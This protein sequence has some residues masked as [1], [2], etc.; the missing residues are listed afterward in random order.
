MIKT[1]CA[2]G[3]RRATRALP[4]VQADMMVITTCGDEGSLRSVALHQLKTQH[5]TIKLEGT[6]KVRDFEVD[7]A[8]AY[9]RVNHRG[10]IVGHLL[11]FGHTGNVL[12]IL[13]GG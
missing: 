11:R 3:R 10:G 2:G 5:A 13:A 1:G 6:F 7:M 8:D 4:R 9:L 12:S